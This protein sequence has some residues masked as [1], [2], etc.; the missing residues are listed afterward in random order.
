AALWFKTTSA[1][2]GLMTVVQNDLGGG[3]NDR[4]IYL[5]GGDLGARL[6]DNE[7]VTTAGLNLANGDWHHVAYTYGASVGGQ[8]VYVDGV[9]QAS[10]IKTASDFDWQEGVNIGFSND[11][12][13]PYFEG[14][15]QDVRIYDR[16]LSDEEVLQI[17]RGDPLLAWNP[18]PSRGATVDVRDATA[19][20]WRAGD[21]AASHEVY[22]GTDR[23]ALESQGSQSDTSFS[24]AGRVEFGGG[25][26]YWRID[27][28][29]ADGTV[30]AGNVWTFTIPAYLIVDDFE[31][32]TNEVGSRLFEVWGDGVGFT[33]PEP[34]HP[35]NGTG[36]VVGHDIWSVDSPYFGRTIVET[37]DVHGGGK[38]MPIYYDNA[39]AP[40]VSEADRIF[41]PA[42]NWTAEG[43][44][45]LVVHFR[46][47]AANTS[48]L[49]LEINGVKVP[50]DGDPADLASAEWIAWKIDLA[51]VGTSLT[52]VTS[53]TIG[54]EAG[55]TGVLYVD[56]IRLIKL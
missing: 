43:V 30:H 3:G 44:T 21:T 36:A 29:E 33:L 38:A 28:V 2:G 7:I 56:D 11:G 6:W 32:Y 4:H 19:L 35:G 12:I 13:P 55:Q 23:D 17:V 41:T 22:F 31:S 52:N 14:V 1:N 26:Y 54:I 53:M 37:D 16:T 51:S 18:Q 8:E 24:L 5:T 45:T 34:G 9:L 27:E 25:V 15:L 46:G 47:E 48:Q 50:Y 49:Y 42:Q 39:F 20:S 40:A 10:G